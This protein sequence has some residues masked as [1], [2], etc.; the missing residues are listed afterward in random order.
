MSCLPSLLRSKTSC[1]Q[2]CQY[3]NL[4]E[5]SA[6]DM[7]TFSKH[8][9]SRYRSLVIYLSLQ[10]WEDLQILVGIRILPILRDLHRLALPLL[11]RL[12]HLHPLLHRDLLPQR[13]EVIRLEV[14]PVEQRAVRD[15]FED[16]VIIRSGRYTSAREH[17]HITQHWVRMR[18]GGRERAYRAK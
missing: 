13:R 10:T 18:E 1:S 17:F 2:S 9:S 11:L 15:G 4:A 12:P 14:Q 8:S 7:Y 5:S 3:L 16:H 6:L